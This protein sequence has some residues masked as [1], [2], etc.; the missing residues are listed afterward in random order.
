MSSLVTHPLTKPL[1]GVLLAPPSKYHTHRGLILGA[2]AHGT[3]TVT[4]ISS[5]LDNQSTL[6][7]LSMLGTRYVPVQ[8]GYQIEGGGF[9]TPNNIIDCGNSGSTI[10]FLLGLA[11][12]APNMTVFT[13]DDSLRSRPL[14]PHIEAL[15]RWGIEVWSTRANG[16]LPVVIRH[17]DVTQLP[18]RVMVNGLIS[19]WATGLILLAP[20][21]GHDVTV[22][23]ENGKLNEGSYTLLM[24]KMMK[25]FGVQ[26]EYPDK[27]SSFFIPGNQ[28]YQPANVSI[29]GDIALASFGLVLAAISNSRMR[30]TN[31][32]LNVYHPEAKIIEVLEQ[33]GADVRIDPVA[34]TV[35]VVGGRPLKGVTVDCNDAPDMVPVLSVLLALAE[36]ESRII[37]AEQLRFKEC[38]RLAA[39][40]QLN[41]FGADVTETA[42][43]LIFQ[44]VRKLHGASVDSFHDHRVLMS[45]AVAGLVADGPSTI[46]DPGAA[47]VSYPGFLKD[48][49][50][51]GASFETV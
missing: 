33:M 15:N 37:H 42:D 27:L 22:E 47:A 21:T 14:G 20:F 46:S 43:G 39:M 6:N 23:I 7:S 31:L 26:V 36:G 40:I 8:N 19:Q 45:F 24:I 44:G 1:D 12:T 41:K 51:L 38:D 30:Y 18:E 35:E 25:D 32:D 16:L 28:H 3:S 5:S 48:I 9:K 4:G 13:G 34:K 2:L 29:P 17:K 10:H 50:A 11:A 49:G